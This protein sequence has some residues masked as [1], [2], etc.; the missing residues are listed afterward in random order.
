M[1]V[2]LAFAFFA[3][4]ALAQDRPN[5]IWINAEDQSAH[6]GPFIKTVAKTPNVDRLAV[7]LSLI[8]I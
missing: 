8:H 1:R 2:L 4:S 7:E 6:Y 5:I 3:S